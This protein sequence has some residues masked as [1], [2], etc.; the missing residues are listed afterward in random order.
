[1]SPDLRIA[2]LYKYVFLKE[3]EKLIEFHYPKAAFSGL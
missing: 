1:M 2:A 3:N